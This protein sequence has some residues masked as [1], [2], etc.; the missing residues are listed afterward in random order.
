MILGRINEASLR[1]PFEHKLDD[2]RSTVLL[3]PI[4]TNNLWVCMNEDKT[5]VVLSENYG[6][7]FKIR[8]PYS[9][10]H[11]TD[12]YRLEEVEYGYLYEISHNKYPIEQNAPTYLQ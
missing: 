7:K 1:V 12:I 3:L 4:D 11:M 8:A 5:R 10:K 9:L 6:A 2:L